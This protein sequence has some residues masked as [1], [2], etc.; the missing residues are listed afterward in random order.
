MLK[1]DQE[2]KVLIGSFLEASCSEAFQMD[3]IRHAESTTMD[4]L[5]TDSDENDYGHGLIA[6]PEGKND[7]LDANNSSI[8]I[9]VA[10]K[11]MRR[12]LRSRQFSNLGL[13]EGIVTR[14]WDSTKR[15]LMA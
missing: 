13:F 9:V 8:A 4:R 5:E 12:Y 6:K 3:E 15:S 7:D 1:D 10:R 2:D 11:M 14:A